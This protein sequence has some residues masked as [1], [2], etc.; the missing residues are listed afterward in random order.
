LEGSEKEKM[1]SGELYRASD[2]ELVRE[3]QR[4]RSLL[5]AFNTRPDEEQRLAFRRDLLGSIG[6]GTSVQPPFACDYGYNVLVA[7]GTSELTRGCHPRL[8]AD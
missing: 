5:Q 2:P 6:T 4:C 8:R 7:F 3:R 1:L